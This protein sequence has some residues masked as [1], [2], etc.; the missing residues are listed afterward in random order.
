VA[1]PLKVTIKTHYFLRP[2]RSGQIT[3][4]CLCSGLLRDL[5]GNPSDFLRE[6]PK[7]SRTNPEEISKKTRIGI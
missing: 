3:L 5:F 7:D 1:I 6:P 4:K 2:L